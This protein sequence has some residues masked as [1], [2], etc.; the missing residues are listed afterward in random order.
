MMALPVVNQN[1]FTRILVNVT[2]GN[3][4][5]VIVWVPG[6]NR[7]VLLRIQIIVFSEA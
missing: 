5:I 3:N 6:R 4:R 1:Q 7:L 2:I